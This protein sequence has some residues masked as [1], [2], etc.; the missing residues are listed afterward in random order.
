VQTMNSISKTIQDGS[1]PIGSTVDLRR[2][3]AIGV[4]IPAL[5]VVAN[6]YVLSQ[7]IYFQSQPVIV[8]FVMAFYVL[9]IGTIGWVVGSYIH[10]ALLR[11]F[12][13][14]WIMILIDL[15]LL[16]ITSDGGAGIGG[17]CLATGIFTGQLGI[18]T[19]WSILGTGRWI[20]RLPCLF[21]VLV[22]YRNFYL[23]L[24][25]VN[26]EG[27]YYGNFSDIAVVQSALLSVLVGM[28]RL[29][30]YSLRRTELEQSSPTTNARFRSSRQ[31]GIRDV[32]IWTAALA[33]LLGIARAGNLLN[34]E[35][36]KRFYGAE[37]LFVFTVAV[38]TSAIMI[39]AIW[40]AL[41]EGS[42]WLRSGMLVVLSTSIGVPVG[43]YCAI[44]GRQGGRRFNIWMYAEYWWIGWMVLT[45]L[46]LSASLLIF[47]TQGFRLMKRV[48]LSLTQVASALGAT[49]R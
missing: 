8:A 27:T 19:V 13:F 17:S 38:C 2:L 29:S 20:W 41:G 24:T 4:G 26:S 46:L 35:F 21:V 5:L 49:G 42:V 18:I 25:S 22:T 37:M 10:N 7:K 39:V 44:V 15:Q 9:Q 32:L 14:G 23:L 47:R 40:A 34:E 31:F 3:T 12:M 48:S 43:A 16:V 36:M 6:Q 45:G 33:V 1:D 28:L 11:W 30:G